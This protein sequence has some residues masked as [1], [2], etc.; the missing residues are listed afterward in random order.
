M[1]KYKHYDYSQNALIPV[2][3]EEQ[4]TSGTLEFAI[5][6]LVDR[7]D[8]SIFDHRYKNDETGRLAY[9]PRILLKIILLGY[10]RGI[11]YSRDIERACKENITFMAL[12]CGQKPDHSTIATFVSSM[13]N[14]IKPLFNEVLLVCYEEG[15]LGGT[16]FAIDGCRVSSN[17]S[18]EWSGKIRDLKRKKKK[19]EKKVEQLINQQEK[20]DRRDDDKKGGGGSSGL[21]NREKQIEK[22]QKQA[23]RIKKFLN[24]NK[25]KTGKQGKEIQSNV[26]DNE[27]CKMRSSHGA[28][29]GY[30]AQALVDDKHQVIVHGEAFGESQDHSLIT[31]MLDR[32]KGNIKDIGI[33]EDYFEGKILTADS[34]YHDSD[35]L[36]KCEEE[37]IDAYIPD[38]RFRSRDPRFTSGKTSKSTKEGKFTLK[39]FEYNSDKDEYRCPNNKALKVRARKVVNNR[40][41]YKR[42][43]AH[44]KDCSSCE[45]KFKCM[46]SVKGSKGRALSVPIGYTSDNLSK[47]MADKID[48]EEGRK[49]YGQRIAIVEPV[50]ANITRNKRMNRLTLRGKTKVNIQWMLYCMVHNIGKIMA[51]GYT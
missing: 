14:E 19:I 6:T 5:H 35:N 32:A 40:V 48:T 28:I 37:K 8:T 10:S 43:I 18:Q 2:N 39:D 34:N 33:E 21:S 23:E 4:L 1:A 41:I 25:K 24:K 29:Q 22:L 46:R 7:M 15:L 16:F 31:P 47:A 11:I 49:I 26:T 9:D 38:K 42:Y 30:N 27:S 50:F 36:K 3:L 45:I 13:K 17:A 20:E 44:K 12:S 51:Y